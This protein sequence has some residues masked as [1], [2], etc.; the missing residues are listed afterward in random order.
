MIAMTATD[1][2]S[3]SLRIMGVDASGAVT[4]TRAA[5]VA[6]DQA[7]REGFAKVFRRVAGDWVD[8]P[9][10]ICGMAGSR[11][12]WFEAPYT[13]CPL[14]L[15]PDAGLAHAFEMWPGK[16]G[17]MIGG[18]MC[19]LADGSPEIMRGEE[20]QLAGLVSRGVRDG[21]V[22]L[23]GTHSKW[24]QLRDGTLDQ[25]RTMMTGD[26][27]KALSQH[28]V[29]ARALERPGAAGDA[30]DAG[31]RQGL[32]GQDLLAR[33]FSYRARG[34]VDGV[35][36]SELAAELSGHLIGHEIY[37]MRQHFACETLMIVGAKELAMRY[38]QAA[39]LAGIS[40][41]LFDGGDMAVAGMLAMAR[42][43]G[44]IGAGDA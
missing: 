31:V 5:E 13:I 28:T 36:G 9:A 41:R 22:C 7:Q 19:R 29:L 26:V 17:L 20:T 15:P 21:V 4:G 16:R 2:G 38:E 44:M 6:L 14:A 12:A 3:S 33:L 43:A 34:I 1:W 24:A 32:D 10:I 27:F 30:F 18:A 40:A 23:P 35:R 11:G 39:G 8:A 42:R 25:F 37:H